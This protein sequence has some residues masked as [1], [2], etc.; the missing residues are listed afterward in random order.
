MRQKCYSTGRLMVWP[1]VAYQHLEV[2]NNVLQ[3][4]SK[5]SLVPYPKIE[6]IK[7]MTD[8]VGI[9]EHSYDTEI[10][11]KEGYAT[12][13]NARALIVALLHQNYILAS[14]YLGFLESAEKMGYMYCDRKFTGDWDGNPSSDDHFG[15]SVW[16]VCMA[17][18]SEN[19]NIKRRADTLLIKLFPVINELKYLRPKAFCLIGL[20]LLLTN[21]SPKYSSKIT[22]LSKSLAFDLINAFE[23]SSSPGWLWFEDVLNYDN[24]RLPQALLD[25]ANKVGDKKAGEVGLT[26]MNFLIDQTYDIEAKCFRFIGSNGWFRHNQTKAIDD[27]QP[28]DAAATTEALVEAYRFTEKYYYLDLAERSF[29]WYHG[30]NV[31]KQPLYNPAEASIYDGLGKNLGTAGVSKNQGAESILSYHLAFFALAKVQKMNLPAKGKASLV[32]HVREGIINKSLLAR[33]FSN[34]VNI[35]NSYNIPK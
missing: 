21:K 29:A 6:Y 23:K 20:S 15:R 4:Q 5:K 8:K 28:L 16:A 3:R 27:E 10:N 32:A 35:N 25:Y 12:D 7:K 33:N 22:S 17:S 31:L 26:T 18:L 30:D 14:I 24:A 13:D 1:K 11:Y 34:E 9:F 2:F 19:Q